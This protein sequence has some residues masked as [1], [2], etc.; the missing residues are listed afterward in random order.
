VGAAVLT[1]TVVATVVQRPAAGQE[2]AAG[3]QAPAG[4][5]GGGAGRGGRGM[6]PSELRSI[7]AETT[8]ARVKDPNWKAP[9]TGWGHPDLEG[10]FTSDDF[11]GVPMS[12]PA[13]FGDRESLTPAEFLQRASRDEASR[14]SA[15]NQETFLRNEFGVRS[16]GYT[17]VIVEP[18]TGQMPGLT[19]A[20]RARAEA[21]RGVGTFGTRPLDG[22]GDFSLYDRCITRGVP[23]SV[24]PVLYGNGVRIVQTPNE[25]VLTYEM[26]HDTR[27]IP[28]DGRP[29]LNPAHQQWIGD[30]RGRFEGD[31]LV[32]ET[33]NFTDR[34]SVSGAP[35]TARL[36]LTE[37]FTRVDPEM[38]EYRFRVDDPDTYVA[39]FTARYILTTQPGYYLYE[40]GCHEG[41][42]AVGQG[43]SGER[44]YER[45]VAEARAKGLPIPPRVNRGMEVYGAPGRN[46]VVR[47]VNRDK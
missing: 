35:H 21:V 13:E 28:L 37:W 12:R 6:A 23:G 2:Q 30:S 8:I 47:D 14:F 46:A 29:R 26:I 16:F 43:L 31:T 33:A 25:V 11:R 34:T 7:A 39:P 15:V 45:E 1:L 27:V 22:F 44:A 18:V 5:R 41:N 42:T 40:Y 9:R 10:T 38:I 17:S 32:V 20:A 3:A 19:A 24:T 4:Q 36:R